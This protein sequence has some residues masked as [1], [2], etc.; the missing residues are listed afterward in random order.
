[1]N[2]VLEE[3]R[4]YISLQS[5]YLNPSDLTSIYLGDGINKLTRIHF[6][7]SSAFVDTF[8]E[9][10][11]FST[12]HPSSMSVIIL[13]NIDHMCTK[14]NDY[15][16]ENAQLV[17]QLLTLM[18]GA[19]KMS[20]VI[21]LGLSNQPHLL[22]PALRRPGRFDKE[23]FLTPPNRYER[24][25]ILYYYLSTLPYLSQVETICTLMSEKTRGYVGSDLQL[26]TS[27]FSKQYYSHFISSSDEAKDPSMDRVEDL[28]ERCMVEAPP[29]LMKDEE[30]ID[31]ITWDSIGGLKDVKLEL[32]KVVFMFLF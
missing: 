22:D 26:L 29:S 31:N 19:R 7:S 27:G 13:D 9:A 28:M 17:S 30:S 3:V 24:Y 25:N 20:H 12:N 23:I 18:D 10:D 8:K 14:R 2:E 1:M 32:Q 5:F 16:T 15:N 11:E 21:V 4:K 6:S